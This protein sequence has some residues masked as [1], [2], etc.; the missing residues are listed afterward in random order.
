LALGIVI[1]SA[2]L[3]AVIVAEMGFDEGE[4]DPA[5][6]EQTDGQFVPIDTE[7]VAELVTSYQA[8]QTN[9]ETIF[10]LGEAYFLAGEWQQALEWFPK[11]VAI[12]PGNVHA[13]TDIG[14]S[15]YNL[16][17]TPEAQAAWQKGLELA[18]EDPQLH[19]NMG[20]L[21]ANAETPDFEAA[22]REWQTVLDLAPGT[23][24]AETVQVHM[25]GLVATPAPEVAPAP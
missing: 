6:V 13:W 9:P 24:L 19:Y 11:L 23:Q 22:R 14:T 3:I 2:A 25:E 17:K 5:A 4:E 1:G 16:G 21:Y 20:F 15:N 10:E 12:D 7:R 8:D 18:P